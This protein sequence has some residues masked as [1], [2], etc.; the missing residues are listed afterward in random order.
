M[1]S[2]IHKKLIPVV[3]RDIDPEFISKAICT[4]NTWAIKW[5]YTGIFTDYSEPDPPEVNEVVNYL[6]MW[7]FIEGTYEEL[8]SKEKE[9]VA[10]EAG[11]FGKHVKFLGFDGNNESEHMSVARF[12]IHELNSFEEF[13]DREL[14]SHMPTLG[15]YRRMYT[16]F[17]PLRR[18]LLN[19]KLKLDD[20]VLI[21]KSQADRRD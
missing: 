13:K 8:S 1:L 19:G 4:D 3:E 20:L 11:H 9:F 14:N 17:E 7:S 6:D 12:M 18:S 2:E 16:I 21:L 15:R 5:K 10:T